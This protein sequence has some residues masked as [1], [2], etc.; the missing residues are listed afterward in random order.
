VSIP[1]KAIIPLTFLLVLALTSCG[2]TSAVSV[3][4]MSVGGAR[5]SGETQF[6]GIVR[7]VP[8]DGVGL[9][10]VGDQ[11]FESDAFTTTDTFRASPMMG[12]CAAVVLR[13]NRAVRM[14]FLETMDCPSIKPAAKPATKPATQPAT[15]PATAPSTDKK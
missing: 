2:T 11:T 3:G 8:P 5:P 9:W 1:H 12:N 13:G 6:F 14:V 15:K 7:R 10:M 4:G